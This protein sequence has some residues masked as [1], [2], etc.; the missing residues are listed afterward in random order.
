MNNRISTKAGV[1]ES[2]EKDVMGVQYKDGR[3][4][5]CRNP[6]LTDY[7][8]A[9]GTEVICDRAFMNMKE[10]RSIKL[11]PSLKAIGESAFSGCKA[12]EDISIPSGLT[13]IRQ[14]TFRDCDALAAIELPAS[15]TEI[16]KFAFGRGLTT[17]VVNAPEMKIDRYA[18]M[19]ARDFSTLMVPAGTAGYY[20]N[21]LYD[22][23]VKANVEE[24]EDYVETREN[25]TKIVAVEV[26]GYEKWLE[27]KD[28]DDEEYYDAISRF[29]ENG[30]TFTV[31]G[32]EYTSDD[33]ADADDILPLEQL[34]DYK[35]FD[36]AKF[37]AESG[38]EKGMLYIN[39]ASTTIDIEMPEE[40]SFDPNK[41]ALVLRNFIYPDDTDEP[42]VCAFIYDGKIYDCNPED[43]R[44]ISGERIWPV[45]EDVDTSEEYQYSDDEKDDNSKCA[46][47]DKEDEFTKSNN[48]SDKKVKVTISAT[49]DSKELRC[50]DYMD[51][52][53]APISEVYL[54]VEDEDG[55]TIYE[56][57][58]YVLCPTYS[59]DGYSEALENP[60]EEESQDCIKD[61]K[62][63]TFKAAD[64]FKKVWD[65]MPM[66]EADFCR[67]LVKEATDGDTVEMELSSGEDEDQPLVVTFEIELLDG[68][69]D[70]DKLSFINFDMNEGA[71]ECADIINKAFTGYD[72]VLLNLL[73]YGDTFYQNCGD[74]GFVDGCDID[75]TA[76]VDCTSMQEC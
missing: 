18:F 68:E 36:A 12:L 10:L 62:N 54:I 71:M 57:D 75:Q 50:G 63:T 70:I 31:D 72:K 61:Y 67:C 42:T 45:E 23:R 40:E 1:F 65:K 32:E 41:A 44:G 4:I 55:N 64:F 30:L 5:A 49:M 3:L 17:L 15:V 2:G 28:E 25:K 56:D 35:E 43:S 73:K 21:L 16:E 14:A 69:F 59:I 74:D 8:V 37:F 51:F 34:K 39:K 29:A 19:N 11:P 33:F 24:I 20:R 60:T 66:S 9:E 7:A 13:E 53:I 6:K 46:R 47:V 48:M 22:M 38:A 52:Y 76:T 26:F 27:P 58:E